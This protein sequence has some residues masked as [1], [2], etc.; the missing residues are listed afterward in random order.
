MER[1]KSRRVSVHD[2]TSAH[3]PIKLSHVEQLAIVA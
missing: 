2:T 1:W 3:H